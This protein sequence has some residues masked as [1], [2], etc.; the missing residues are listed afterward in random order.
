MLPPEEA[1]AT[2]VGES[3]RL[4]RLVG[5][6]LDLARMN[7]A[8]FSV[9][10]EPIDLSEIGREAVR[11]YEG[12]ARDFGVTLELVASADA[13]AI[14]DADRVLQIVSNLVENALR[15]A[16]TGGSVRI[17]TGPGELRVEDDRARPEGRKSSSGRSSASTSTPAT[18]ASVRWAPG[19]G[20]RL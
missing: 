7:K 19:L 10:R 11:R 16:P 13:P 3:R 14:G 5:D 18:D 9:R 2:I 6:L 12:Q 8:E 4:E 20:S 15:L 1:A 17:V